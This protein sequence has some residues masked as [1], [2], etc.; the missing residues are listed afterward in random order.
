MPHTAATFKRPSQLA[1]SALEQKISSRKLRKARVLALTMR[2]AGYTAQSSQSLSTEQT[3]PLFNSGENIHWDHGQAQIGEY[4]STDSFSRRG[5][6]ASRYDDGHLRAL[7]SKRPCSAAALAVNDCLMGS[8]LSLGSRDAR[9][10]EVGGCAQRKA[11]HFA[12]LTRGH[13]GVLELPHAQ[14]N[15]DALFEQIDI[16]SDFRFP[17]HGNGLQQLAQS[18]YCLPQ[19]STFL[20]L[21]SIF[22]PRLSLYKII[23]RA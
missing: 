16:A 19:Y 11:R 9:P 17:G 2:P 21:V 15:V 10:F 12:D 23:L 1:V 20:I 13:G 5:G 4:G 14:G 7:A 18:S 8:Q 22:L 3:S 6:N